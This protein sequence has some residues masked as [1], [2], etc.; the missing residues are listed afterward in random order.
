M[1]NPYSKVLKAHLARVCVTSDQKQLR[2]EQA[3]ASRHYCILR[4]QPRVY[5]PHPEIYHEHACI[6]LVITWEQGSESKENS[7]GNTPTTFDFLQ[8]SKTAGCQ[9]LGLPYRGVAISGL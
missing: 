1:K 5:G 3:P 4:R 9:R 6:A 2:R 7:R 8:Q